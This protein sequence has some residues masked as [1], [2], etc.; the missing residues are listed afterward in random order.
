MTSPEAR[1][2]L[3]GHAH[4]MSPAPLHDYMIPCNL[5]I[6]SPA[7]F[8]Q[9]SETRALAQNSTRRL[10]AKP[11][12]PKGRGAFDRL[13]TH[14]CRAVLTSPLRSVLTS[15]LSSALKP[16][17]YRSRLPAAHSSKIRRINSGRV[18][19]S[20]SAR[21]ASSSV[22][23]SAVGIRT[24]TGAVSVLGLPRDFIILLIDRLIS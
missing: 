20:S 11:H 2:P 9:A 24:M 23:I 5:S 18:G 1:R 4:E 16:G 6:C 7:C 17:S 22:S 21:R 19:R 10:D 8:R 14:F 15:A 12:R 13:E 3:V